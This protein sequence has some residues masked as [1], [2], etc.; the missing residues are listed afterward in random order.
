[1]KKIRLLILMFFILSFVSLSS[2]NKLES[3]KLFFETSGFY[4]FSGFTGKIPNGNISPQK[5]YGFSF[6]GS[7]FFSNII[8]I[9][10]GAGYN[11]YNSDG[12][13]DKYL[14]NSLTVDAENESFEYRI[15]AKHVN[16]ILTMK[17]IEIP[18]FIAIVKPLKDKVTLSGNLG[19]ELVLPINTS[20]Q[21]TSDYIQTKG[22]YSAYNVEFSDMPN[23]G[24][25]TIDDANYSGELL[26]EISYA[27]FGDIRFIVPVGKI[28]LGFSLFGFY[29]L[30]PAI[31]SLNNGL[32]GYPGT[33]HS[34]SS[35]SNNISLIKTG[36]KFIIMF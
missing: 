7:Y 6:R 1:M 11:S 36:A 19:V 9:G 33:Y 30:T 13:L 17:A 2:Q 29:G 31:K 34:I 5:D 10:S 22:Y 25:K 15:N 35:L 18:L 23:H 8:G 4:G 32:M 27:M 3:K 14:S 20:Y 24:F 12:S 16:E 21:C 28:G 26:Y